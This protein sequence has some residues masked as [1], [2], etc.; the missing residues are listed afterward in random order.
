PALFAVETALYRLIRSW[1]VKPDFLAGHSVGEI[2]AAHAAGVLSLED[3]CRL[4]AARARLMRDLPAGG[5]MA[6]VRATEDE[7]APLL[8]DGVSIAAV[9]GPDALVV[10]GA[11]SAVLAL[12]DRLAAEGRKT[13]RLPVSHAFHSPLMEPML[14]AFREVAASLTFGEASV[15]VVSNLTGEVAA[16]GELADPDYW[17]RHVR[18][19]VRFGDGVRALAERGVRTFL[20]LGPDAVLSALVP[21]SVQDPAVAA[22]PL[23]RSKHPEE[24]S[25]AT[26]L[27]GLYTR[28]IAVDWAE[29]FAG[30]GARRVDLPTY[31][32]QRRRYWPTVRAAVPADASG[33]GLTAAGHPLLGAAVTVAESDET[34]LTGRLSAQSHPW[35]ADHRADGRIVVPGSA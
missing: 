17:V 4:V 30:T 20:E 18:R 14:D 35:L 6:A 21:E 25:A 11:E 23:L 34:V 31:P 8:T 27:A 32:F 16:P 26:A 28:G 33:L 10:S 12:A 24:A 15:P 3:A 7:V 29:L 1:G 5:A 22:L 2:T 13:T 9:N 19:S